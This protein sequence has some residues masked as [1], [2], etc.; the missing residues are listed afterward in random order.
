MA[1]GGALLRRYTGKTR[2]EG[3][4]PSHSANYPTCPFGARDYFCL[5]IASRISLS[6]TCSA[7]GGAAASFFFSAFI[8]RIAMKMTKAMITKSSTVMTNLP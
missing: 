2:I 8:A 4:N 3:S 6:S 5:R 1:E 7:E